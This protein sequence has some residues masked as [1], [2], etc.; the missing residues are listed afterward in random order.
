LWA[1]NL[2]YFDDLNARGASD[3]RAWHVEA[4]RSWIEGNPPLAAPAW[5]PYPTSLR[6]PNWIKWA[7]GGGPL[8][9]SMIESLALQARALDARLEYHLLGNH[10]LAN[11][12]ALV[13]AGVFFEGGE[14]EGWLAKGV[15]LLERE[16]DEQVLADGGHFER[17]PMYHALVLEDM[18]DLVNL[19]SAFPE[20]SPATVKPAARHWAKVLHRMRPWL[21]AMTHPDG[22]I[23]FFNDSAIGIAPSPADIERY[24]AALTES[25][26]APR[27]MG[28]AVRMLQL[29][30]SGYIRAETS[31]AVM[32]LDVAPIGPDYLPGHA[33]AD[34]LSFELSLGGERA[35]VNG[36]TSVYEPG[37]VR[38]AERGTAAHSTVVIDGE[39]SS[40]VWASFRV[41][42]RAHPID[43]SIEHGEERLQ[44]ACSHDG[45]RRLRGRP[46]HRRTWTLAS[47]TLRIEDRIVGRCRS[48]V[49]YYHLH[50]EVQRR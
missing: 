5:E 34:T 28:G 13:F 15:R 44:V 3:R 25:S 24:A 4:I 20:A 17:S 16:L 48:A 19:A 46:I 43:L 7:L 12:K 40:E 2:H 30:Q 6:I 10:L 49:A 45:Y 1:Y 36:G 14:A 9:R 22:E 33:H 26:P 23:S 35:I 41:A 29:P 50:P 37:T 47:G 11:A 38:L 32:L 39:D 8:E 42:R 21:L 27:A 18:A 31:D